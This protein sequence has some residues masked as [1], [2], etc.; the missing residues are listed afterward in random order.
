KGGGRIVRVQPSSVHWREGD[1]MA[2]GA[3]RKLAEEGGW[4]YVRRVIAIGKA[5]RLK[6]ISRDFVV[7]FGELI[8]F[9]H[10]DLGLTDTRIVDVVRIHGP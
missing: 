9:R 4:P 3:L 1:T 8:W 7:A 2:I 5:A 10:S 6:P